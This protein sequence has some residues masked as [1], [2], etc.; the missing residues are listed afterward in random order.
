MIRKI[1]PTDKEYASWQDEYGVIKFID[2]EN[3]G[4]R[5]VILEIMQPSKRYAKVYG[6]TGIHKGEIIMV[7]EI[8]PE[9]WPI[10]I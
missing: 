4:H 5:G 6:L 10:E 3:E 8:D 9:Q 7:E 1:L 2:K